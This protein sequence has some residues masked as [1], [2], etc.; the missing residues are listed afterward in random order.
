MSF[1]LEAC[2]DSV[3]KTSAFVGTQM[4]MESWKC[5]PYCESWGFHGDE[6]S[7]RALLGCDAV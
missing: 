4:A 5:E 2:W 1:I 3:I 7:S 6:Y